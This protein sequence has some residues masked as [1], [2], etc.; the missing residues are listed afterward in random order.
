MRV[1]RAF[2]VVAVLAWFAFLAPT[3][4]AHIGYP[5][6]SNVLTLGEFR[7]AVSPVPAPVL[8]NT[9]TVFVLVDVAAH[10]TAELPP[11]RL[12]LWTT[13]G[14]NGEHPFTRNGTVYESPA[15]QFAEIGVVQAQLFMQDPNGNRSADFL[16]N[17]YRTLP[18]VFA[19]IDATSDPT[20]GKEFNLRFSTLDAN[21]SVPIDVIQDLSAIVSWAEAGSSPTRIAKRIEFLPDGTGTWKATVTFDEKGP[22]QIRLSSRSGGF[23]AEETPPWQTD[24]LPVSG[25]VPDVWDQPQLLIGAAILLALVPVFFLVRPARRAR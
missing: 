6:Q 8:Q 2:R 17:V 22:W 16:V 18:F 15:I 1:N 21:T 9:P 20:Q 12:R 25:G 13:D 5:T 7:V 23:E 11:T 4:A 10:P 3:G 14:T 24:V 19:P